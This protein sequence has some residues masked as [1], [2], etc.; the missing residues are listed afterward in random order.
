MDLAAS[1]A[2]TLRLFLVEKFLN[3][4]EDL[5]DRALC[6]DLKQT[7]IETHFSAAL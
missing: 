3:L 1:S 2:A 4:R 7:T 5:L 6:D